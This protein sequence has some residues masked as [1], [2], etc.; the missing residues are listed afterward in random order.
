MTD[1]Q[2]K[3]LRALAS[4]QGVATPQDLRL[5]ANR[6]QDRARQKSKREGLVTFEGGYWRLTHEGSVALRST[7]T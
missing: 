5:P 2:I 1:E 4:W 7:P 3:F 6:E